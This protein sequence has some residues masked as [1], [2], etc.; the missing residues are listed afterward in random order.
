[1]WLLERESQ[2]CPELLRFGVLSILWAR[3]CW[4]WRHRCRQDPGLEVRWEHSPRGGSH[5]DGFW[6]TTFRGAGSWRFAHQSRI[7]RGN[8][9]T[10]SL[11]RSACSRPVNQRTGSCCRVSNSGSSLEKR[12]LAAVAH[13]ARGAQQRGQAEPAVVTTHSPNTATE[14][15]HAAFNL[16]ILPEPRKRLFLVAALKGSKTKLERTK[17]KVEPFARTSTEHG[18]V[19]LSPRQEG[20]KALRRCWAIWGQNWATEG[21]G[22]TATAWVT[23]PGVT[24]ALW[25]PANN[26]WEW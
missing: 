6:A 19:F 18:K 1:M 24:L 15:K 22:S 4:K 21:S 20:Q 3:R 16:K 8:R 9:G 26:L 12:K 10:P 7:L 13:L 17:P 25:H 2:N 11:Q 23:L 5:H 14:Q